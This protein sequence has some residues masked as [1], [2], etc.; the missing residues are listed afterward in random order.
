MNGDLYRIYVY[1]AATPLLGL[2]ITLVAYQAAAW[3]YGRSGQH[4][5]LNPVLV[6]VA[7][8]VAVLAGTGLDYRTY[9]DGAHFVHFL[10]GP[11]TVALA[12]PLHREL[13]QIR[14]A[15]VPVLVAVT[16]GSLTAIGSAAG[17]A[18]ALGASG[19][20]IASLAPKSATAPVAMSLSE[21]LGGLPSLTAVLAV[22]TGITGALCGRALLDLVRIRDWRAHGL[23]VGVASHGIGTARTLQVNETG[24]AFAGLGFALNAIATA[25]LL[26]LMFVLIGSPG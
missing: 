6:S 14:R 15:A 25:V 24:G 4:P 8:I 23:G 10:L 20:M 1:L 3:V 5:L 26:P 17:I 18:W 13:A 11:V 2:T 16:L 9:F 22:L 12:V 7:I 21:Q 19:Q